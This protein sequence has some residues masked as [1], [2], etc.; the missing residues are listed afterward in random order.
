MERQRREERPPYARMKT[1]RVRETERPHARSSAPMAAQRNG[2]RIRQR[3][4]VL[5][6]ASGA[7]SGLGSQKGMGIHAQLE[8]PRLKEYRND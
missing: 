6:L 3:N 7:T 8:K 4:R 1:R 5:I 2:S